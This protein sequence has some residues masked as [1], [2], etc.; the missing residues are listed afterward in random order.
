M[1]KIAH[2]GDIHLRHDNRFEDTLACLDHAIND[3]IARDVDLFV[4]AGDVFDTKSTP[5]ERNAFAGA[6]R[7]MA[8]QAPVVIIRGNHDK[9]GDLDIFDQLET[10][11]PV[12]VYDQPKEIT[13]AGVRVYALPYLDKS[14]AV[15]TLASDLGIEETDEAI[16]TLVATTLE[17]WR[18]DLVHTVDAPAILLGHLTIAGSIL[19]NGEPHPHQGVQL[20]IGDFDGFDAAMLG[21]IHKAQVCDAAGRIRYPGSISRAN[22]G[23]QQDPK[24]W[25]LWDIPARGADPRVEFVEVPA[26]RMLTFTAEYFEEFGWEE[27]ADVEAAQGAE[28]R[29]RITVPEDRQTEAA[30]KAESVRKALAHAHSLKVETRTVPVGRVRAGQI[31]EAKTPAEK[32]SA[33]WL[34]TESPALGQDE[35]RLQAKLGELVQEVM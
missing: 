30:A 12:Y 16:T 9:P 18:G 34:A 11:F 22:F 28:V 2:L 21:H 15:A 24:G 4:Q 14:T 19:S 23:E 33:Y 6:L 29:V 25:W 31:V 26:R 5:I 32:L 27:N 7:R 1:P 8:A 35:D 17:R 10:D 20:A 13:V 3:A